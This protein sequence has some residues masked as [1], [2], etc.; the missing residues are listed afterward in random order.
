[1]IAF[2]K[3]D[4]PYFMLKLTARDVMT[5]EVRTFREVESV[6]T[7]Y[8]TLRDTTHNGFPIVNNEHQFVGLILRKQLI[9]LLRHHAFTPDGVRFLF[10]V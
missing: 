10:S 6:R 9:T 2:L 1:M 5:R 7:I 8:S 3:W 4:A